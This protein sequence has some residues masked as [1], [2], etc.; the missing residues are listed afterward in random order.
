MSLIITFPSFDRFRVDRAISLAVY[1]SYTLR[2]FCFYLR[3]LAD[4]EQQIVGF[5][6]QQNAAAHAESR[7]ASGSE[8][9]SDEDSEDDDDDNDDG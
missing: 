9:V 1:A 5:R 3:L 6:E 2:F 4:E 7:S 8:E